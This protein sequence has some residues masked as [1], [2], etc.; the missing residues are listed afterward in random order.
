M[1]KYNKGKLRS[2][3][4]KVSDGTF[5]VKYVDNTLDAIHRVLGYDYF[6]VSHVTVEG[7]R[8][9]VLCDDD[10]LLKEE[11]I[12][13]VISSRGAI[14]LVGNLMFLSENEDGSEFVSLG[15]KDVLSIIG[16]FEPCIFKDGVQG[17]VYVE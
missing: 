11:P 15:A 3:I 7:K 17:F 9:V 8:Y 1:R 5:A 6:T 12:P 14:R 10:G 2:L 13:S 16:K 4:L